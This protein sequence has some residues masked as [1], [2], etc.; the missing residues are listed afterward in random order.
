MKNSVTYYFLL[1]V[2]ANAWLTW[3]FPQFTGMMMRQWETD[4]GGMP[5][6][7]ATS[8]LVQFPWWPVIFFVGSVIGLVLGIILK[9]HDKALFHAVVVLLL[10]EGF[11]LFWVGIGHAIPYVKFTSPLK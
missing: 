5:L 3:F 4:L 10:L 11:T 8:L 6:P 9:N 2:A 1:L 7:G